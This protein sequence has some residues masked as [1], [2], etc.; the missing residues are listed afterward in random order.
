MEYNYNIMTEV[1]E[2]VEYDDGEGLM[3]EIEFDGDTLWLTIPQIAALFETGVENVRRHINN[4][5][6]DNELVKKRT[7]KESLDVVHNRPNFRV[8]VYNLDVVISVGYRV[9]STIATRFR[10]WATIVIR[11]RVSGNYSVLAQEEAL[12][13][14]TRIQVDDSTT[15]LISLATGKHQVVD[16][17]SF[18][19]AGDIGLYRVSRDQVEANRGIPEG[20]LYDYIGST[21]LGMHVFRLTQTAEALRVDADKGN[22]LS[23]IEAEDIHEDIATRTRATAH[24]FHK[25]YPEELPTARNIE[26][27]R[28][29]NRS[30]LRHKVAPVPINDQTELNLD[31]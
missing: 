18:L 14:L 15:H 26:L 1:T 31:V 20:K 2:L 13:L 16:K 9:K 12:R 24:K 8:S 30:L 11:D 19:A 6:A 17:D 3:L 7:S 4:I 27:V 29:K 28:Q 23:Q 21:E 5:Y 22:R 25:Q 10:Q